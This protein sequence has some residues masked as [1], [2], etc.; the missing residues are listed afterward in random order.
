MLKTLKQL[1]PV[2]PSVSGRESGIA[3]IIAEMMLD[4]VDEVA[5]DPMGNLIC[6]KA[7]SNPD[8]EK[9]MLVAHMDEI[10]FITTFIEDNGY[11]R[12]A[13]VG[14]ISTTA[15]VYG[16]VVFENGLRGVF[17]PEASLSGSD[18]IKCEKCYIDIGVSSRR[19]AEK[20]VK[21][22]DCCALVPHLTR[23]AGKR[24]VGRPLDNRV[25]CACLIEIARRM[26]APVQDIYYVFSVQEE[27]GCRGAR[28]AAF[29]IMPDLALN[30]DITATGDEQGATPM[31]VKLG[32]GVAVKV[33]DSSV[34]CN[35]ELVSEL[36]ELAK[37]K[38]IAAQ[39]EILTFGGTDTSAVQMTGYGCRAGAL[40]LPCRYI[41]SGVEMVDMADL[42]A[43]V[44]LTVAYLGG[45]Q[46]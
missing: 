33:K 41:H 6:R 9:V 26:T 12:V 38:K 22:G 35:Q 23:L 36:L 27:V 18:P 15:A 4:I 5:L 14:G 46:V 37:E 44:A 32:K 29:G 13:P 21:I 10:G 39:T 40:S 24:V 45:E 30:F 17:V 8:A 19:E 11:L 28:P 3:A 42:E 31:A 34:I 43:A 2:T 16:E 1:L 20:R 25:G 7:G